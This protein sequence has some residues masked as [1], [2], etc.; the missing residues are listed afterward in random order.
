MRTID[1]IIIHCS[2]TPPNM[3]VDAKLVDDWHKQR[4]WSGIGYHFFIKRGGQIQLGRPLEKSGAHTKGLN[5]NSIGICYAGGVK[6]KRGEDGKWD[7]EDN[8][9]NQQKDSLLSLLKLL[10]N[11]FPEATIHGHNEFAR[12]S[13]PCFDAYNEYCHL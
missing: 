3:Y 13:C 7:A 9:T 2:A 10:K 11:M 1:E 12:K 8:R 5:P 6:E 4:G